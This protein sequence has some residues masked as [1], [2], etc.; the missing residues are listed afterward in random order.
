MAADT[1]LMDRALARGE[2][3]RRRSAPN[4]WVGAVVVLDG[5]IVG[6]GATAAVPAAPHAEVE[7]LREAGDRARGA[8]VYTTLE[9]CAHQGR[10]GP[11]VVALAEAGVARVVVARR[12]PRPAG[13]RARASPSCAPP[14]S[15]STSGSAPTRP[16]APSRPTCSTAAP[17]GRS[18]W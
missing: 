18:R 13:G 8:T 2:T 11:C 6:Q 15:P 10:T 7:A 17:D 9:P 1:E 16:P 14:A 4:P 12:G 3:A 5:E